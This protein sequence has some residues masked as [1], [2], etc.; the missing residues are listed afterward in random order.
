MTLLL[1]LIGSQLSV[2]ARLDLKGTE[3][4]EPKG[5]DGWDGEGYTEGVLSGDLGV[6]GISATMVEHQQQQ[7]EEGLVG[8]L[9]PA[10]HQEGTDDLAATVEAILASGDLAGADGVLHTG[11]GSHGILS[12]RHRY[13]RRRAT[14][15]SK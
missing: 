5:A 1:A 7:N 12:T 8:K 9:T 4:D 6:G 10:L 15:R 14:R 2:G 13:R 11:S 3:V